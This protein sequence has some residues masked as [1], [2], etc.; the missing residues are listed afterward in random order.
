MMIMIKYKLSIWNAL[1]I[2][3]QFFL[4]LY[5]Y[6]FK[7][8][9]NLTDCSFVDNDINRLLLCCCSHVDTCKLKTI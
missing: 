3:C 6:C 7:V 4:H 1:F 2:L 8:V 9:K 5:L